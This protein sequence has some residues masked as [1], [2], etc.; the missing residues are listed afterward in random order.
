MKRYALLIFT[1]LFLIHSGSNAQGGIKFYSADNKLFR[2]TGR[3]DWSNPGIP[4]FWQPGVY[5]SAKFSGSACEILLNDEVLWGKS[6]NYVSVSVDGREPRRIRM[7]QKNDTIR[8]EGLSAG[9]HTIV[10]CKS[11]EAGIG[12][13]EF[14]GLRCGALQ[15][16][17]SR[18]PRR[19]E[20]IGNSITCGTG[21]DV[22]EVPCGSREWYDQHNAYLSYGPQTARTLNAEWHL[23]AV[24][25]I[26]LIRSCCE[27]EITMPRVFDKINMRDNAGSW[28]FSQF[29]PDVVTIALGQN[30]GRQDSTA[31]SEAYVA[32]ISLVRDKYPSAAI[33]CLTSPMADEGL[34]GV[35][36]NYLSGIVN[37]V[38]VSGDSRVYKFF[39]K[40]RYNRGCG[41]HPDL[42]QHSEIA[43][44]LTAFI[45]T[46][47][48][49]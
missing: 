21:S 33:V 4:R 32:F 41:D 35:L 20:F 18:A 30:D 28:D 12:Y 44:E 7:K 37:R 9:D 29:Q 38:N 34:N 2:Y 49:W 23:S 40:K 14:V 16:L 15:E 6:F 42:Q 31:F 27:M 26:G 19:I 8:I 48:H 1:C 25:G 5:I 24:S 36:Q 10:I 17:P 22:S 45:K 13:L 46:I 39:F 3:I 11:T 47:I 43:G